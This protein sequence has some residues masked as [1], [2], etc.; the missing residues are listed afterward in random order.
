MVQTVFVGPFRASS[1]AHNPSKR[2][3]DWATTGYD[4]YN[5][6]P[7]DGHKD[8]ELKYHTDTATVEDF[9]N[10]TLMNNCNPHNMVSM[11]LPLNYMDL[12]VGDKIHIPLINNEKIFNVDYSKVDFVNGQPVYPLWVVM[13]TN[14][15]VDSINIKAYQLHYLG[16]DGDHGF[17]IPEQEYEIY[18]NMLLE[19]GW[20][21]TN[22]DPIPNWNYNALATIDSDNEI[23]YFDLNGDGDINI[24]D[25]MMV[26]NHIR[27]G[28]QLTNSQK[29]RL[30]YRSNGQLKQDN[31]INILDIISMI[32]IIT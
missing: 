31:I 14:I 2:G 22:G 13:E 9:A 24:L 19:S 6:L 32:N 8:I 4:N 1:C 27:G 25:I 16:T 11:K 21:F 3:S 18:G 17:D 15:G 28:Q 20:N 5:L 23:P 26:V 30:R 12:A 29:E 10:Y 7:I